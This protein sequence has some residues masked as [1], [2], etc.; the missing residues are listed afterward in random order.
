MVVSGLEYNPG[1]SLSEEK[2]QLERLSPY[3]SLSSTNCPLVNTDNLR[4][5]KYN[6]TFLQQFNMELH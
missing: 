1:P 6:L 2:E 4:R 3:I 5:A